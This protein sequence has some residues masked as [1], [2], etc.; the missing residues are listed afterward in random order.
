VRA[1]GVGVRVVVLLLR[2]YKIF[3]SPLFAGACRFTPS[4]SEYMSEA[5]QRHGVMRG[6]WF[7]LRRLAR[8][9]PLGGHGFDP[10][11]R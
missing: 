11:P 4:C 10:V 7:G 9:R 5:V 3:V 1:P 8:C 6:G 2:G